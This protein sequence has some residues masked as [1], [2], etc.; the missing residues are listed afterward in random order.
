MTGTIPGRLAAAAPD[1]PTERLPRRR[2]GG[3]P[4]RRVR[5]I[6]AARGL[7]LLGM[8]A[9]HT[10]PLSDDNGI[11][12]V[13]LVAGG[14]SAALF[15]V[16]AGVSVALL[17]GRQRVV[18]NTGSAARHGLRLAV[19]GLAV[20]MLGL[21][22]GQVAV[23]SVDIILTY[24]GVLFLLAVPLVLLSTRALFVGAALIVVIAPVISFAVRAQLPP[25]ELIDP[26]FTALVAD[27]GG[28]LTTLFFTGAYPVLPW[29]AYLCVGI[30]VGRCSL[31]HI[32]TAG[33]LVV[34]GVVLAVAAAAISRIAL[35]GLGGLDSIKANPGLPAEEL[36]AA[37]TEGL[38]GV[39]PTTTWWWLAVDTAHTSTPLSMART[40]GTSLLVL[41]AMLLLDRALDR[42]RPNPAL[43]VAGAVQAPLA[44][45]GAMTLTFYTLHVIVAGV[46][47]DLDPWVL[48]L[49]QLSF[50]LVVGMLWQRRVGRGPLETGVSTLVDAVVSSP[51]ATS[52]V[53]ARKRAATIIVAVALTVTGFAVAAAGVPSGAAA[54]PIT[55][56]REEP[57]EPSDSPTRPDPAQPAAPDGR[58]Q[59]DSGDDD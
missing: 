9:V 7:A 21:A 35:I 13:G 4:K 55:N 22:L 25:T 26:S 37:L 27:P 19:R 41:G 30:G 59:P 15:A 24:Y 48:Y 44:A 10:F 5:G 42:A 38:G 31:T 40:I 20:G 57:T 53:S 43:R 17:T 56:Q 54:S 46:A 47:G 49:L 29:L 23:G 3:E 45:A 28:L 8:I 50:A 36:R 2:S 39:T 51:S 34:S 1:G 11:T 6:D 18:P 58:D 12:P 32:R 14:N 52:A 16:L 33:R